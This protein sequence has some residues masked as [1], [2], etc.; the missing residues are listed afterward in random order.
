MYFTWGFAAFWN[1]ISA[2]LPFLMY[3]EVVEKNNYAALLGLLFTLVGIWLIVWAIRSTLEWKRF[4]PAPV[5]LDPFPGAI[6]GHVG[7]TID[8]NLPYDA[9][10]HIMLTLTNIHSHVSG[11]GKNRSRQENAKWQD[12]QIAHT[13]SGPNGTRLSFRF[14]VPDNLNESDAD[15]SSDDY[16]LWRLNLN[17][18]VPGTDIDRD[19]EIPVYATGEESRNI[20]ARAIES[21]RSQ[22]DEVDDQAV[23][24]AIQLQTGFNGKEMLYPMG[25]NLGSTF[26]AFIV[27]ASFGVAGWWLIVEE[28]HRVFGSIFG[29]VGLLIVL[30]GLYSV[31]NSL[32]VIKHAGEL[33][34][35]R[36]ILG[37]PV[38]QRRMRTDQ[39]R[40]FSKDS[41]YKMQ[42]GNKHIVYYTIYAEDGSSKMVVGEGFKGESEANAAI[43]F[44]SREFGLTPR[45]DDASVTVDGQF[46]IL[47]A[48]N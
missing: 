9:S 44:L 18:D 14:D 35:V 6:G 1:L 28:G 26:G 10:T 22:T 4:G 48:D 31:L 46:D 7:G 38:R 2:P 17:A 27:G 34:A 30:F 47:A 23:R 37:I 32:Q 3:R 19:Y 16:Y 13:E 24:N 45:Q 33:R 41:S 5:T 20:S 36:R 15:Q 11:S 29:G 8:I 40:Q 43:R 39:I 21:V 12:K 25:R 42:S